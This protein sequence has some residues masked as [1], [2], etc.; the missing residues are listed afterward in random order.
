MAIASFPINYGD[1]YVN[2]YKRVS[3]I[4]QPCIPNLSSS[5][6]HQH[7]ETHRISHKCQE[8]Q[9]NCL[10]ETRL[11]SWL[12]HIALWGYLLAHGVLQLSHIHHMLHG[13]GILTLKNRVIFGRNHLQ[14]TVSFL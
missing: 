7:P 8:T 11:V 14:K 3:G 2:V 10:D 6:Y 12:G 13:A 1:S 5:I 9:L 4:L